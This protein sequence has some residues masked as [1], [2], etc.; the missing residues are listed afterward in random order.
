[1][2][3]E[4]S[5]GERRVPAAPAAPAAKTEGGGGEVTKS[6]DMNADIAIAGISNIIGVDAL[7][8]FIKGDSRVSVK[9]AAKAR[10]KVIR[11]GA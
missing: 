5:D 11:A 3:Q 6:K 1:M 2:G 7:K 4:V 8:A 9:K 10:T